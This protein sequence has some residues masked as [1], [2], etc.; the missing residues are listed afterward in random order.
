MILM[1]PIGLILAVVLSLALCLALYLVLVIAYFAVLVPLRQVR[2][3]FFRGFFVA[4]DWF[5]KP[6][7]PR[8]VD[9]V[10]FMFLCIIQILL[11]HIGLTWP[12]QP[13]SEVALPFN[14]VGIAIVSAYVTRLIITSVICWYII[15]GFVRMVRRLATR[16]RSSFRLAMGDLESGIVEQQRGTEREEQRASSSGVQAAVTTTGTSA[17]TTSGSAPAIQ[18]NSSVQCHAPEASSSQAAA[19]QA[20]TRS[21]SGHSGG[22]WD[23]SAGKGKGKARQLSPSPER[24]FQGT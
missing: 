21:D 3:P 11:N 2:L 5:F 20:P 7:R 15:H 6:R 12:F 16:G 22:H 4:S 9:L 17:A 10:L 13:D 14:P 23:R 8:F 24:G 1:L 19:P 18:G